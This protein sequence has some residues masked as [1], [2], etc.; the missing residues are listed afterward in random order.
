MQDD[1]D[2]AGF[3][4]RDRRG[5]QLTDTGTGIPAD[6]LPRL[7]ER[8]HRVRGARSRSHEGSASVWCW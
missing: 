6:E 8:F 2:P 3:A 4:A 5:V 1:G 7:F